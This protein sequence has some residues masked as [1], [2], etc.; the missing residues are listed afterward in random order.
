MARVYLGK[1]T[2]A[3]EKM[4]EALEWSGIAQGIR[5][6]SAVFVKPNLT[7]PKYLQGVTTSPE[8]IEVVLQALSDYDK[9]VYVGESDGGYGSFRVEEG[10]A[11]FDLTGICRRTGA[12]LVNLS[13]AETVDVVLRSGKREVIIALPRLLCETGI[14]TLTM[15]VPK[16]HCMTGISLSLKNQWG[17]IP[18]TM[19]LRHHVHFNKIILD[20]N[21]ALNVRYSVMDGTFG[22]DVNGPIVEG[23]AVPLG[24][25]LASSDPFAADVVAAYLIGQRLERISHYHQA[26][27]LGLVPAKSSIV[28]N[29]PPGSLAD[30]VTPFRLKRNLWNYA[31]KTTWYSKSWSH[32]VYESIAAQTLHRIM[33]TFRDRPEELNRPG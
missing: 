3:L 6:A 32:F 28:T 22:L 15:P 9:D 21:K 19:R 26:H 18:D 33:Y 2:P 31:A 8:M 30:L 27:T 20:L 12:T 14:H 17:C 7:F 4:S 16:V 1:A 29:I 13:S 23:T 10:F 25:F 24:W 11:N 5:G